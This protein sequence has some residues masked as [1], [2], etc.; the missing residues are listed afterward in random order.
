MTTERPLAATPPPRPWWHRLLPLLALAA[1]VIAI[2]ASGLDRYLSFETLSRHYEALQSW[3]DTRPV[4]AP[5][6]F[7]LVYAAAVAASVPGATILTLTGGLLFGLG[8]GI[9]VVTTAATLGASVVFLVA[10]TAL[11]DPLRR[12]ID[13][14]MARMEQGFRDDAMSY[15]LVLRLIPLF[16]FW[17][18]NLVP[19]FLGVPLRT[20]ALATFLG[21]LPGTAVYVSVGNGIGVV[22]EQGDRPDLGLVFRPEILGPLIGLAL[23]ALLPVGYKR[24]RRRRG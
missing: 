7:G 23:L 16:P 14:R 21:I 11:G 19:A 1:L 15:L 13:G 18:V 24:W 10:K 6:V 17:L 12:H 5:L 9:P 4:S 2:F 22:L 3:A 20:Y 8:L